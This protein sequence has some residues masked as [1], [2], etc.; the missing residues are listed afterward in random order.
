VGRL[1]NI[2]RNVLGGRALFLDCCC[3]RGSDLG[4]PADRG[5]DLVDGADGITGSGLHAGDRP[6]GKR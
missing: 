3:D 5:P 1:L 2:A 6:A 4:N